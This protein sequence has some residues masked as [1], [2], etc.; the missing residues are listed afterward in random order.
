M[1]LYWQFIAN[2]CDLFSHI[3]QGCFT[4]SWTLEIFLQC[5]WSKLKAQVH[6]FDLLLSNRI[7]PYTARLC[8]V[9]A[10]DCGSTHCPSAL[11]FSHQVTEIPNDRNRFII[12][13]SDIFHYSGWFSPRHGWRWL[14]DSWWRDICSLRKDWTDPKWNSMVFNHLWQFFTKFLADVL[15]NQGTR[16]SV[17][18]AEPGL[19]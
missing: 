3:H 6:K 1:W 8:A 18:M 12:A 19:F 5:R 11:I 7:C 17:D 14:C 4:G 10:G 16:A 15:L 2:P 13:A 9:N